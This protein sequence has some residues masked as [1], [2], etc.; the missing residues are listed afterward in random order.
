MTSNIKRKST[1]GIVGVIFG[2]LSL[3]LAIFHFEAGPLD[4]QPALEEVVADKAL[5]IKERIKAKLKGDKH[6]VMQPERKYSIDDLVD[7]ATV[8]SGFL[9]IICGVI[10]FVR[11][12]DKRP[13]L[14]SVLLG[15]GAI[16]FQLFTVALAVIFFA[17]VLA[18]V[19]GSL[20][21]G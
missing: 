21:L 12:E 3:G 8:I 11:R 7:I 17:I 13:V 20:G 1:I 6:V 16:G 14:C 9:A 15:V 2:I 19:I 5:S 10:A 18:A 4:R